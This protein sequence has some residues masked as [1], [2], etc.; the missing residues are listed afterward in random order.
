MVLTPIGVS[1]GAYRTDTESILDCFSLITVLNAATAPSLS[2][3]EP[4]KKRET[5]SFYKTLLWWHDPRHYFRRHFGRFTVAE[6]YRP[7]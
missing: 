3:T 6:W 5:A 2:F 7:S 4:G 1:F